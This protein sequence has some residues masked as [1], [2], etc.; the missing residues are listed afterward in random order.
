[1]RYSRMIVFVGGCLFLGIFYFKHIPAVGWGYVICNWPLYILM[2]I[3]YFSFCE[4]FL[5]MIRFIDAIKE[6]I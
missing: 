3:G 2:V 4:M 6:E 5:G 1:M